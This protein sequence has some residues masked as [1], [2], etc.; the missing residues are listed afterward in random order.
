MTELIF[1]DMM[2][3]AS[4]RFSPDFL[5]KLLN[6]EEMV[7]KEVSDT[8]SEEKDQ[9]QIILLQNQRHLQTDFV[10]SNEEIQEIKD[11]TALNLNKPEQEYLEKCQKKLQNVTSRLDLK[12]ELVSKTVL[13][14]MLH[15]SIEGIVQH[16]M[17]NFIELDQPT[18]DPDR[19]VRM[20][21]TN[22]TKREYIKIKA[23]L[24]TLEYKN[25]QDEML[26]GKNKGHKK[27]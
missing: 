10:N 12:K 27:V 22:K 11:Y 9:R 3:V 23:L 13:D 2:S 7:I 14:Q 24:S 20:N 21:K 17:K 18:K 1:Y 5:N 19:L 8:S 16:E 25:Q 4:N 26:R 15:D 6:G